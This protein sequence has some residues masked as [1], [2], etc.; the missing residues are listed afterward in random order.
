ME[1]VKGTRNAPEAVNIPKDNGNKDETFN[2]FLKVVGP[3][4]VGEKVT[5]L[6]LNAYSRY[7]KSITTENTFMHQLP[8][9]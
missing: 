1:I 2:M 5:I 8:S 9:F 3:P 7:K 4:V 6:V